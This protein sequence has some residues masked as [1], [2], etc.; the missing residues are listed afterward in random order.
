MLELPREAVAA[1]RDYGALYRPSEAP[2]SLTPGTVGELL[3]CAFGLSAWKSIRGTRWALRVNPSSGNLH[4][5]EAYLAWQAGVFHYAADAH[6]LER[7]G[8]IAPAVWDEW[9]AGG[10]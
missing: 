4:P 5:T 3:R 7:R 10:C 1:E 9:A 8:A 2:A 6:A